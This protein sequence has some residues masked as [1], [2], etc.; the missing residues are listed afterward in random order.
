MVGK[1]APYLK[2]TLTDFVVYTNWD[3][4]EILVPP[5]KPLS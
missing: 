2:T 1:S 5:D 4:P 3:S